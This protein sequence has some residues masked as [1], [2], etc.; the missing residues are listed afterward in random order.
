MQQQLKVAVVKIFISQFM[1]DSPANINLWKWGLC[2]RMSNSFYKTNI[3]VFV[4]NIIEG[5]VCP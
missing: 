5:T 2:I 4:S 1:L 3:C